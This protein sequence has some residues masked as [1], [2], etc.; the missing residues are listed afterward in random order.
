[1]QEGYW[2]WSERRE[3]DQHPLKVSLNVVQI[4]FWESFKDINAITKLD[5][6]YVNTH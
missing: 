2:A 1:M 4:G 5:Y 3:S 6:V